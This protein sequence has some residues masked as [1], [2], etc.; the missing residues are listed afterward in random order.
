M[1]IAS[2]LEM[3]NL[4]DPKFIELFGSDAK[5]IAQYKRALKQ[6]EEKSKQNQLVKAEN[7]LK[8]ENDQ[9]V[10]RELV[11]RNYDDSKS[12]KAS[13]SSQ[14][15]SDPSYEKLLELDHGVI[16]RTL[17]E[18]PKLFTPRKSNPKKFEATAKQALKHGENLTQVIRRY[19]AKNAIEASLEL[20]STVTEDQQVASMTYQ[21]AQKER[22]TIA[23][24]EKFK[25]YKNKLQNDHNWGVL[26]ELKELVQMIEQFNDRVDAKLLADTKQFI[27]EKN[28][29]GKNELSPEDIKRAELIA[30]AFGLH[31]TELTYKKALDQLD[32]VDEN[33]AQNGK[34]YEDNQNEI[35]AKQ[36]ENLV[37]IN[38]I[39]SNAI[40]ATVDDVKL[41][42]NEINEGKFLKLW[43]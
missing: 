40:E 19:G 27:A 38:E 36:R 18:K 4:N 32:D 17:S 29:E 35:Q 39:N 34:E 9:K 10:I 11:S 43:T 16:D 21:R 8:R 12:L 5:F 23:M 14:F 33:E 28:H 24:E 30:E 13:I 15:K 20:I 25:S 3:D 2:T 26:G 42:A 41:F 37:Q 1:L 22:S 6:A 31:V 7:R